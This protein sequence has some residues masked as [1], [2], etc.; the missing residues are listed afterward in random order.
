VLEEYARFLGAPVSEVLERVKEN[1]TEAA[2]VAASYGATAA[3]RLIPVPSNTVIVLEAEEEIEH[4]EYPEPDLM[5]QL[6]I[7]REVSGLIA[8]KPDINSLLQMVLEGIFRGVGMDRT[9]FALLSPDRLMLRTKYVLGV[10][11]DELAKAFQ[12][13]VESEHGSRRSG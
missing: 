2:R 11:R 12:F 5:L 10:G 6:K 8:A 9:L 3:A 4:P 7:L 1:A 13:S